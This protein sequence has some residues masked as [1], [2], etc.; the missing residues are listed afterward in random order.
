MKTTSLR[1]NIML[2]A[3]RTEFNSGTLK[4]YSGTRPT[5]AD[6][7]LSGN[8]LL[9]TLTFSATAFP[10]ASAGVLTANAITGDTSADAT[11][12]ATFAR[13]LKSDGTTVICDMSVTATGGGGE[14]QFSTT[15]FVAA[16]A[17]NISSL[18]ITLPVGT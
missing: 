16:V 1:R 3:L 17:V 8:T 5:D 11:G 18:T 4:V 15:S 14:V 7:A 2:D 10:A 12:T 13:C 9:A 6:T